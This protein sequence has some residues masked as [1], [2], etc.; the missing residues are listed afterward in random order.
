MEILDLLFS[1][2]YHKMH[3]IFLNFIWKYDKYIVSYFSEVYWGQ[4]ISK[5]SPTSDQYYYLLK[6]S[7]FLKNFNDIHVYQ[8][9]WLII[10]NI[11]NL[12][13]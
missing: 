6:K 9:M 12:V 3:Y 8:N 13:G 5:K 4:N 2:M 7:I 1:K 11:M 10:E